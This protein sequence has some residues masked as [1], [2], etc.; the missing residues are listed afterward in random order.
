MNEKIFST[1]SIPSISIHL[2]ISLFLLPRLHPL[3]ILLALLEQL[4][5]K[6]TAQLLPSSKEENKKTAS[7]RLSP[8]RKST[9][10]ALTP[11]INQFCCSRYY[12]LT[13]RIKLAVL[14]ISNTNRLYTKTSKLS[15]KFSYSPS[16]FSLIH[17]NH[18]ASK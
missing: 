15:D 11:P 8:L 6:T 4:Q 14:T 5:E 1:P 18:P 7:S 3:H 2:P 10:A 12:T 17:S 16:R 13:V 9:N